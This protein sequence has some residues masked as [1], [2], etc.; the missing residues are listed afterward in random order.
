[1]KTTSIFLA[2]WAV[3]S[4]LAYGAPECASHDHDAPPAEAAGHADDEHDGHDDDLEAGPAEA[5]AL[6]PDVAGKIGLVVREAAGGTVERWATFP[7]EVE[8]NRDRMAAVTPRVASI[9]KSLHAAIGDKVKAG[10]RLAVLENRETLAAYEVVSP[11]AGTVISKQVSA[12]ESAGED[13]VL[14][15]VADLTSAWVDVHVFPQY[16]HDIRKGQPVTLVATDG[17][18]AETAI[19]YV[20]PL[21]ARETRTLRARCVLENPDEDFRPGAFV[22]ARIAVETR[23]VAVAVEPAAVQQLDGET[24]VFVAAGDGY[25]P[26]VVE[27][28]LA[29]RD[30]LEIRRGLS[31]GE[32]YVAQGAFDLKAEIVTSGIDPHAGHGH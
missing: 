7:A 25:A 26:R 32:R 28:G 27:T 21:L 20:S 18:V 2:V 30:L 23:R 17:H 19:E 8:L 14:F 13:T 12:G 15:E 24:V 31:P 22:R 9:V 6:A 10:D 5:I 4:I 29:G 3:G 11:R 16:Q 1:M